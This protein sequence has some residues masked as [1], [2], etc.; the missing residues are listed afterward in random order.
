[1]TQGKRYPTERQEQIAFLRWFK[2][3]FSEWIFAIP[4]GACTNHVAG[5]RFNAEGRESG[6]PDL[7]VPK[8]NLWVEMKRQGWK[9]PKSLR[10]GTTAYN[11]ARWHSYLRDECGHTVI[12]GIG[13]EDAKNKIM[14]NIKCIEKS[15]FTPSEFSPEKKTD[16][17]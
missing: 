12:I 6:V 13:F 10:R 3:Q 9:M 4:N 16:F 2:Y 11:Q 15:K 8:W 17:T 7:Y 14:R 5:H 1:M